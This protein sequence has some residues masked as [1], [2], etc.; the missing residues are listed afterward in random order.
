MKK[1]LL[2]EDVRPLHKNFI[3]SFRG[4]AEIV[5]A[6]T[7]RQGYEKFA[8]HTDIDLIVMDAC[9]EES[10]PDTLYLTE[11]IRRQG[12]KGPMIASSYYDEF[13]HRQL[14]AGCDLAWESPN[15]II[16][17]VRKLLDGNI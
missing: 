10:M 11:H 4:Q 3:D 6:Y 5:S 7:V 2:I 12:Y 8:G 17:W 15:D 14:E 16:R 1:I 13:R 9:L